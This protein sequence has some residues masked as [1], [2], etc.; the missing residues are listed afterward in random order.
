MI[1]LGSKRLNGSCVYTPGVVIAS[2]LSA[3]QIEN[4]THKAEFMF[5]L[6]TRRGAGGG[7]LTVWP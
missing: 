5:H 6:I 2:C 7:W 4:G 3:R 1:R